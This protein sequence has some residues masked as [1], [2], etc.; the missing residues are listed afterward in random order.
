MTAA[1]KLTE[2]P[3]AFEFSHVVDYSHGVI[4]LVVHSDVYDKTIECT[5]DGLDCRVTGWCPLGGVEP[6]ETSALH[7][8][9]A[10]QLC[11]WVECSVDVLDAM[12]QCAREVGL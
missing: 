6:Y 7:P 3:G 4:T 2:T 12:E 9:E 10:W 8:A 1:L 5:W 11:R